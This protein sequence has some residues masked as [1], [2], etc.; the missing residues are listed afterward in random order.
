M[1]GMTMLGLLR[2]EETSKKTKVILLTNLEP[3]D[4]IREVI[5]NQS[6]YY[7]VKSDILFDALLKTVKELLGE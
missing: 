5:S 3:D 1:D 2:K 4:K 6:S 7:L